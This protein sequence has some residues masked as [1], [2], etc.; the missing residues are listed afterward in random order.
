V[1]KDAGT[2][3]IRK[4][5]RKLALEWHPDKHNDANKEAAEAKF[6]EISEAYE[7]LNDDEKRRKY[8][9]GEDIQMD[10]GEWSL[11]WMI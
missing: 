8:D 6:T 7:V 4:A 5:Y 9:N 2:Q 3:Q 1:P 10:G 11:I